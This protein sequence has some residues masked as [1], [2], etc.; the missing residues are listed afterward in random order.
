VFNDISLE[1]DLKLW[2]SD[3]D[4]LTEKRIRFLSEFEQ[5]RFEPQ[6]G[7]ERP[8]L[9]KNEQLSRAFKS[10]GKEKRI[11]IYHFILFIGMLFIKANF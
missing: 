11:I 9:K 3:K 4:N 5:T 1:R 2:Q 6:I 10:K 8:Q 7:K